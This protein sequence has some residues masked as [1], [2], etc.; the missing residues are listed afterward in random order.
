MQESES[1]NC[2]NIAWLILQ[3]VPK[4]KENLLDILIDSINN[5]KVSQ[6]D[7]GILSKQKSPK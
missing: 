7:L 4:W 2:L 6:L 3:N 5:Y 1:Y